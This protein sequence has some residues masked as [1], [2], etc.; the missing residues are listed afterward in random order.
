MRD[1]LLSASGI[2]KSFQAQVIPSVML[3]DRIIR[4][5]TKKEQWSR[6][7]LQDISFDV[8]RGEWV[9]LYGQNGAG[10]TTL[11]RILAGLI[12]PDT[13]SVTTHGTVSSFFDITAGFHPERSA[14]ENIYL[15]GLLHGRSPADIRSTIDNIID[16]AGV[17]S[18]RHLPMKCYSAGMNLRVGFAASAMMDSDIYLFDEILAV[19]DVNFQKKCREHLQRLKQADKT[20]VMVNHSLPD[21]QRLCDRILYLEDGRIRTTHPDSDNAGTR[22]PSRS[23]PGIRYSA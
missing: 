2:S 5:R 4:W 20:V 15:H 9:G 19:G 6:D 18:H 10:K 21:L 11:L 16:F 1:I 23:M 14:P 3:Q 7:V 13:G 12:P 22:S 8:S 17:E